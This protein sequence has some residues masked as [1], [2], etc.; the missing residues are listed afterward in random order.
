MLEEKDFNKLFIEAKDLMVGDRLLCKVSVFEPNMIP[1]Q[2][3]GSN[4]YL[5]ITS[6]NKITDDPPQDY[7]FCGVYDIEFIECKTVCEDENFVE[8]PELDSIKHHEK[9]EIL[10]I[11]RKAK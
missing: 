7:G 4:Y 6:V 10:S 3:P 2:K 5:R 11:L 8:V 1:G 9:F